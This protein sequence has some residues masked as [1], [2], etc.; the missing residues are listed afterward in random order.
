MK[1]RTFLD[2]F[3]VESDRFTKLHLGLEKLVFDF[4]KNNITEE[5]LNKLIKWP[6]N[7]G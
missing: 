4:S 5:T 3:A 6:K 1:A 7:K 2:L